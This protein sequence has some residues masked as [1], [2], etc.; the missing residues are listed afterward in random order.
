MITFLSPKPLSFRLVI[1]RTVAPIVLVL[2]FSTTFIKCDS[3]RKQ[4]SNDNVYKNNTHTNKGRSSG[5]LI[6]IFVNG[7]PILPKK[8]TPIRVKAPKVTKAKTKPTRQS[9]VSNVID[10]FDPL[11][12]LTSWNIYSRSH[13]ESDTSNALRTFLFDPFPSGNSGNG[14]RLAGSYLPYMGRVQVSLPEGRWG[15]ICGVGW[16]VK[17]ATVVCRQLGFQIG[18]VIPRPRME[19]GRPIDQVAMSKVNCRG[20]EASLDECEAERWDGENSL[21]CPKELS[22][23]GLVCG[24]PI[25]VPAQVRSRCQ[26]YT[27]FPFDS[28]SCMYFCPPNH[29]LIGDRKRFCG[30]KQQWTGNS[31]QCV[32]ITP[33]KPR[34]QCRISAGKRMPCLRQNNVGDVLSQQNSGR[35]RPSLAETC[36][37]YGCCYDHTI[38][39]ESSRC[40]LPADSPCTDNPCQNGGVCQDYFGDISLYECTCPT[41]Y[42]GKN[43]QFKRN[44]NCGSPTVLPDLRP[45]TP[46]LRIVGGNTVR[47]GS[48]PWIVQLRDDDVQFCSGALIA[49]QWV[50]TAAHCLHLRDIQNGH[51]NNT[52]WTVVSGQHSREGHDDTNQVTHIAYALAN[53]FTNIDIPR[54]DIALIKLS[55]PVTVDNYTGVVC[56]PSGRTENP[57]PRSKCWIAGWGRSTLSGLVPQYLQQG[58]IPILSNAACR[59]NDDVERDYSAIG[60]DMI[61][62][63]YDDGGVDACKGD[64]GGPLM[65]PRK[66]GSWYLAGIVSWG[67]SCADP[68][69]PGVYTRV[70]HYLNWIYGVMEDH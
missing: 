39:T 25:D 21:P 1:F 13:S 58:D 28:L 70:S 56:V 40:F 19:F 31:P 59:Q 6:N 41:P 54:K 35:H 55:R 32:E 69:T 20:N 66:D 8:S 23:A 61:C 33:R 46:L 14:I 11:E 5:K 45:V 44:W 9:S 12:G 29:V 65:C 62:A 3:I 47:K 50:L 7:K 67:Y 34:P 64:S 4:E 52:R 37:S 16:D 63:G 43:C 22:A 18:G 15:S 10:F 38:H 42:G 17:D 49:P 57:P 51:N 36:I 2:C 68:D 30:R 27:N 26:L 24:C 48:W 53:N 60:K